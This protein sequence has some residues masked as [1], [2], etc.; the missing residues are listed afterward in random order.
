MSGFVENY[1]VLIIDPQRD[2]LDEGYEGSKNEPFDLG[3][4]PV[5][6]SKMDIENIIKMLNNE[7][8]KD[9]INSINV[10]LDTHTRNHIA[11]ASL[12]KII[13]GDFIGKEIP[14]VTMVSIKDNKWHGLPVVKDTSGD[15]FEKYLI[16]EP[17][18]DK[19]GADENDKKV[20]D[21]WF[22][23]YYNYNAVEGRN[24]L[25]LW[26]DHCI[27]ETEGHKVNP[28]LK[29]ALNT[30]GKT[31]NYHIK[32]Q[33]CLVEMFS[34]MKADLVYNNE[35]IEAAFNTMNKE[36]NV[37]M[38]LE[39]FK[40]TLNKFIY[41]G[42]EKQY[43]DSNES[44]NV[45]DDGIT[46]D[47]TN[48]KYLGT[49]FNNNLFDKICENGYPIVI[50]GEALSHCVLNSFKDIYEKLQSVE[51]QNELWLI[52]N[53]SKP[54]AGSKEKTIKFY[55]K[56]FDEAKERVKFVKINDEGKLIEIDKFDDFLKDSGLTD[57]KSGGKRRNKT[58]KKS[59]A[60][61][62]SKKSK[63]SSKTTRKHRK[64]HRSK[65]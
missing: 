30:C 54:I 20:L 41:T 19:L 21:T 58:S 48:R 53:A 51:T 33:N 27:E 49:D 31:V 7:E 15:L 1:N 52:A 34:I 40:T 47:V 59:K 60:T 37:N 5:A 64:T 63:K 14:S 39:G 32:G 38:D 18:F 3:N 43:K 44:L 57:L 56:Y 25:T 55:E 36:E 28:N 6:G 2:F 35:S 11:N 12:W 61:K 22:K 24:G 16:I 29:N 9:K 17:D 26:A 62:K 45:T 4:L 10:S 46:D 13:E 8:M 65:R 50:C 23:Y 42:S